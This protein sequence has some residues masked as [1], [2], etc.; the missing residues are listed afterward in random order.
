MDQ[1]DSRTMRPQ[2]VA[3]LSEGSPARP[4]S[5]ASKCVAIWATCALESMAMVVRRGRTPACRERRGLAEVKVQVDALHAEPA[6]LRNAR[7][8]IEALPADRR[9]AWIAGHDHG[10]ASMPL[11]GEV[12]GLNRLAEGSTADSTALPDALIRAR[13]AGFR[14]A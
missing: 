13:S 8:A 2:L 12:F 11:C 14:G 7:D 10:Q 9:D 3:T 4:C 6:G 1:A 5:K